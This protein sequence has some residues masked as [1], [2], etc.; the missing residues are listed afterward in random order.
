MQLRLQPLPGLMINATVPLLGFAAYSGTGKTTL[1]TQLLPLL[2]QH[3]LR[4][5]V[6]KHSHH[7]FEID[8]PGKDSHQLR[9]AGATPMLLVSPYRRV[10]ISERDPA[11]AVTLSDQL[12]ALSD[13]ALDLILVE[14]FRDE[15]F[16]KIELHRPL[17]NK[18]LLYPDDHCIIAIASDQPLDPPASLPCLDLN[19]PRLIADFIL[20]LFPELD[21]D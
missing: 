15:A 18:P 19:Q 9:A 20:Q 17:L 21:H 4:V 5:A 8:Q 3:G 13:E 14:G 10:I 6:I 2:K 12:Q 16:P 11:S 7:D 1:L